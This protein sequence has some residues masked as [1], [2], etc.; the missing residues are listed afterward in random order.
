MK[1]VLHICCGVCAAGAADVLLQEGHQ[2]TGYFYN[3][4]ICPEEEYRLRLEAAQRA[5]EKLKFEL[6]AGP[7]DVEN[8]NAATKGMGDEPEG[9]ARCSVC[10]RL[11]L[12]KTFGF[13]LETGADA[14]TSTLTISPH[15]QAAEINRIGVEIGGEHFMA[16]DFKKKDGFKR[17][18]EMARSWELY[19][20]NYC[21]CVYS[22][23]DTR[24]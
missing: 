7:Y 9:G 22:M 3:P 18:M 16:R 20:Q 21:G 13:L 12:E 1:V 14:F 24:K 19:R 23:R 8:W 10:Y 6:V 11:R 4:N 5:A 15:K 2:V 17:S